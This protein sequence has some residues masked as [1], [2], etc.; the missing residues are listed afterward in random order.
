[1]EAFEIQENIFDKFMLVRRDVRF[2]SEVQH[3][4]MARWI[5]AVDV[6]I[7]PVS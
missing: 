1:M 4:L 6:L 3:L 2:T 5:G 7:F